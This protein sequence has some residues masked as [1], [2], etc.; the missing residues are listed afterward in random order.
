MVKVR[1][2]E[3]RRGLTAEITGDEIRT[4]AERMPKDALVSAALERLEE[5]E[6]RERARPRVADVL[7]AQRRWRKNGD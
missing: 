5:S 3:I 2:R 1:G 6:A 4:L 7:A